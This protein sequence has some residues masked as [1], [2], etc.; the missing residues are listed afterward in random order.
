MHKKHLKQQFI[1]IAIPVSFLVMACL[2]WEAI[3]RVFHVPVYILPP[4]SVI[5]LEAKLQ[6]LTLLKHTGVTM[7]EAIIGFMIASSGAFILATFFAHWRVLEKGLY[8][9]AIALKTTPIVALAPLLV[10]WFGTDMRS[11]IVAAALIC[12][13]PILVNVTRGLK[14]VDKEALDLFNSLAASKW[15]VFRLLRFPN[16]IPFL[17][18]ALNSLALRTV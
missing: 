15:Q 3:V 14:A 13:F 8:P 10:L 6:S 12:F 11:K 7:F 2:L 1:D 18:S 16:S 5:L 17:F 4:P 9:Y